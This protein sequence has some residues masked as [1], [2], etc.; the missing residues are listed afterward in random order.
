MERLVELSMTECKC[1][2]LNHIHGRA[3][4]DYITQHLLEIKDKPEKWETL[5]QCPITHIYWKEY[6][7]YSEAQAGGPPDII[8]LSNEEAKIEFDL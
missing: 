3:A 4:Q 1:N 5:Y 6:Y 2:E 8:Q 7:P